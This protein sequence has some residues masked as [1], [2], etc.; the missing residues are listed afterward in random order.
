MSETILRQWSILRSLPVYP[1]KR[2]ARQIESRL[3]SDGFVVSKRTIE[4]DLEKLSGLWPISADQSGRPYG[5]YWM[6]DAGVLDIPGMNPPTA[7]AFRLARQYLA[8]LLPP[9]TLQHLEPHFDRAAE[10]LREG[11]P[12]RLATWPKKVKVIG[13]G[14]VLLPPETVPGIH[15]TVLQA[16]LENRR[17]EAR[18]TPRD[19]GEERDYVINPLGAVFR[20]SVVYIVGTLWYYDDILQFALHRFTEAR[21]TEARARRPR[22]FDL[23]E[24]IQQGAFGYPESD[25]RIRLKALFDAATAHHLYETPISSDQ[26]LRPR[27]DGRVELTATVLDTEDLRWWLLGF[28]AGVEV[29]GPARLRKRMTRTVR[30]MGA[31]YGP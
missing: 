21:M 31:L 10:V 17:I 30:A 28:G 20:Q 26:S 16:L 9:D 7:L 29:V 25:N 5:W 15:E 2:T 11:S 8:P 3:E 1:R 4:R 18:Y 24:Y 14:P 19:S 6:E 23:D 22:G 13:H 27:E 12:S